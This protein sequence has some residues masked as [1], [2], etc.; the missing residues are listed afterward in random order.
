MRV[1]ITERKH[2]QQIAR[3]KAHTGASS[4]K[5]L[6]RAELYRVPVNFFVRPFLFIYLFTYLLKEK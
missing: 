2:K 3:P 1:P 4:H 6:R 5:A